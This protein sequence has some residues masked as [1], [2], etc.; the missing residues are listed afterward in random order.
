MG[1]FTIPARAV[2][3]V[4]INLFRFPALTNVLCRQQG[5]C[6]VQPLQNSTATLPTLL[7]GHE[8]ARS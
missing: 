8:Q 1:P 7:G 6:N 4:E 2:R 5:I 3:L